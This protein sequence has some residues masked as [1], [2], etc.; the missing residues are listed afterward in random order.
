[1]VR[2]NAIKDATL[3]AFQR[4]L[5]DVVIEHEAEADVDLGEGKCGEGKCGG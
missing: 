2:A 5:A 4:S 1:M 3:T